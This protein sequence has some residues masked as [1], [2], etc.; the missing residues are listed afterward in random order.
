MSPELPHLQLNCFGPPSALLEGRTPHREVL[1]QK[2]LGLLIYLALSPQHRRTRSQL[3][4]MFWPEMPEQRARK[5]LNEAVLR[6]RKRLGPA[7][8]RTDGDGLQLIEAGLEVD[9]IRFA[10]AARRS[11][12][13]AA[14]LWH[15]E[16]LE[17]FSVDDSPAFEE[18]A[19]VEG[20]RYRALGTSVLVAT[21]ERLLA[22]NQF[23]DAADA[24]RRALACAPYSEPAVRVLMHAAAL[25]GDPGS[26]LAAFKGFAD[27]LQ[28]DL[29]ERP[30]AGLAALAERIRRQQP[31]AE[32]SPP[33]PEPPLVGRETLYRAVFEVVA[34]GLASGSQTLFVTGTPGMGRSRLV[35]EALKR[36]ALDGALGVLARPLETDHDAP[37]S[38]LR[39]LLRG[40]LADAPGLPGARAEALAAVAGLLPELRDRFPPRPVTDVADMA[41][42]LASVLGAIA[43]ERPLVV[44]LD[45]AHWADGNS[46]A[47]LA[48]AI[49]Q[50]GSSRVTLVVSA[51]QGVGDLPKDLLHLQGDV[52][53]GLPGIVVRLDALT[54]DDMRVLVR[55]LAPWCREEA[56][57]D[58]LTRRLTFET[59]GNP[60]FAVTLLNALARATTLRADLVAWPPSHAPFDSSLPFSIPSLVRVAIAVRVAELTPEAQFILGA[61][62]IAGAVLDLDVVAFA[63]DRKRADVEHVL[64]AFER[65]ALIAFDGQRYVFAAPLVAEVVR[66]ECV[67]RGERRRLEHRTIEALAGRGDLDSRALR[68]DLLARAQPGSE[69]MD[70]ALAVVRDALQAGAIR[71][72]QRAFA[73]AERAGRGAKVDRA[74][75]EELRIQL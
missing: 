4:G 61:A 71:L 16:F 7:R 17:G 23:S 67:P 10:A 38:A 20:E 51:A 55:H 26:A 65:R 62:S 18:W 3:V 5:A 59:A 15:G 44:A 45:D 53:R 74:P 43:E 48:S 63:A 32:A 54:T 35:S 12:A 22:G 47:A 72:A 52:G 64:P 57:R 40:G 25:A 30:S 50:M 33:Q 73:A 24:A 39:L 42:A 36:A 11:P 19:R 31:Q 8:L 66:A 13:E 49:R 28:N 68:A 14:P 60:F 27:R 1:W 21:G 69:A 70:V 46:L 58:R 6:L 2:H 37:W 9:A 56:D 41:A 34:R 75:L 29:A